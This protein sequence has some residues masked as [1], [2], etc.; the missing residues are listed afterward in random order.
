MF[1]RKESSQIK[2]E[3]WTAFGRYMSPVPSAE[4]VKINW[5]NYHTT[6]KDIFFR[7]SADAG[8]ATISISLEHRNAELRHQYFEKLLELKTLIHSILEEEWQWEENVTVGNKTVSRISKTLTGV[9]I[10]NK[11]H[12]PELISFFKPRMIALDGFW[13]DA[14]WGFE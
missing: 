7:M 14:K 8:S 9:S 3:F 10:L 12:W 2:H 11:D 4:G 6:I 5:V 1:S 13:Q